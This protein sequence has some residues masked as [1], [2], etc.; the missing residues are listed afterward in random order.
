MDT[1]KILQYCDQIDTLVQQIRDEVESEPEPPDPPDPPVPSE[2]KIKT[3]WGDY[4]TVIKSNGVVTR[5]PGTVMEFRNTPDGKV[6][7][8]VPELQR[9]V[10]AE[11]N[12]VANMLI[13]N[14]TDVGAWESFTKTGSWSSFSLRAV[15]DRYVC[16]E[17]V[18]HVTVDRETA[19]SWETFSY[20]IPAGRIDGRLRLSG[21][22]LE[23]NA[24][25][26]RPIWSSALVILTKNDSDRDSFLDWLV[27]TGFNGLRVF[28]GALTWAPQNPDQA[29]LRLPALMKAAA[30]RGLYVEVSSLTDTGKVTYDKRGHIRGQ[31]SALNSAENGILEFANEPWHPTQDD[32]TH[33][34]NYLLSL[35]SEVSPNVKFA[36]GAAEDDESDVYTGGQYVTAHLNRGRDEWNMVRRVRELE[37]LSA[38]TQKFVMNNEPIKAGSQNSN[39]SIFFTMAVL[40]RI[41]EV[42]GIYHSDIGLNARVPP[43]NSQD[44][45]LADSYVRGARLITTMDKMTFKN[46]TW[47]DSPVKSFDTDAA[48]RV[49]SG[50]SPGANVCCVLGI[51]GDPKIVMQNEWQLGDILDEM[52]QVKVYNLVR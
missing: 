32:Q 51:T 27:A 22:F 28:G 42:G 2:Q 50:L 33:D 48:V 34:P 35:R 43:A 40:N 31:A 45:L 8:W 52:P 11:D 1:F 37:N 29:T 26:Y 3:T 38:A 21:R 6:A 12:G 47:A 30:D 15:N 39:P 16:A 41:F 36:L 24:G 9:Y 23:N 20:P 14:R 25:V 13:A 18:G 5:G 46:A 49:Y 17:D 4:L 44:Q 7:L 10:C 19:G